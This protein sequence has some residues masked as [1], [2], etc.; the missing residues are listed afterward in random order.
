MGR[1]EGRVRT[2]VSPIPYESTSLEERYN[3][4]VKGLT[5]DASSCS[6]GYDIMEFRPIDLSDNPFAKVSQYGSKR[7][8]EKLDDICL[9]NCGFCL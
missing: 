6:R 8:L 9:E 3:S 7:N 5:F 2:F 1:R 4:S